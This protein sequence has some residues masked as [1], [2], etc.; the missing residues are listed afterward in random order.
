MSNPATQL[1]PGATDLDASVDALTDGLATMEPPASALSRAGAEGPSPED[2]LSEISAEIERDAPGALPTPPEPPPAATIP[3][4]VLPLPTPEDIAA[5]AAEVDAE[6]DGFEAPEPEEIALPEPAPMP[7]GSAASGPAGER[8]GPEIRK[9]DAAL[10]A[11]AERSL[12]HARREGA[13]APAPWLHQPAAMDV[14]SAKHVEP[15]VVPDLPPDA[16]PIV[17]SVPEPA[18]GGPATSRID[19]VGIRT[20]EVIAETIVAPEPRPPWLG[21]MLLRAVTLPLRPVAAL[22]ERFSEPARQTIGYCALITMFFAACVWGRVVFFPA[23]STLEPHTE[24]VELYDET[25]PAHHVVAPPK[26]EAVT[27]D[28]GPGDGGH[29]DSGHDAP[30]KA[31]EADAGHGGGDAHAKPEKKSAKVKKGAADE[32][33]GGH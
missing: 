3:E 27:K 5:A 15:E 13:E 22:H 9:L 21:P 14:A 16:E 8:P 24:A 25:T 4:D 12:A 2:L 6:L 18:A 31:K 23:K 30:K 32:G 17:L 19:A 20:S 26:P 7:A 29:G 1:P 11:G 10:A 33:H 28:G